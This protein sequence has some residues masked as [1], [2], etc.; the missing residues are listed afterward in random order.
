[1][2]GLGKWEAPINTMI[3]KGTGRMTISDDNGS[4][5][6]EFELTGHSLPEITVTEV[7]ENGNTL[8]GMG[9]CDMTGGKQLPFSLEFSGD[10]FTGKIKVP[11]MGTVKLSGYRI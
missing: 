7:E 1:M 2:I 6:F 11:L 8:T 9:E 3:F 5:R 10:T 4:Y